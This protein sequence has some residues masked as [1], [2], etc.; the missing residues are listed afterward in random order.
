[1]SPSLLDPMMKEDF[2]D[3][4]PGGVFSGL[5]KGSSWFRE[6]MSELVDARRL[7]RMIDRKKRVK[8]IGFIVIWSRQKFFPTHATLGYMRYALRQWGQVSRHLQ[9]AVNPSI[10][11]LLNLS[12]QTFYGIACFRMHSHAK[13]ET[14]ATNHSK[15][16]V[17]H[18]LTQSS[19]IKMIP[20]RICFK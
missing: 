18:T 12:A 2:D 7:T 11:V 6:N 17:W 9:N 5:S 19:P 10:C 1:M 3:D 13:I 16:T 8:S 14:I 20:I 15:Q 4:H